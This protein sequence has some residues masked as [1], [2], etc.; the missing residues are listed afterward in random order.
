MD[1]FN[2]VVCFAVY[3]LSNLV[4][5][6]PWSVNESLGQTLMLTI[7]SILWG[8]V[9][10]SCIVRY[11]K[12]HTI[13]G[14]ILN[15]MIFIIEAIVSG[16][17]FFGIIRNAIDNLKEPTTLYGWGFVMLFPFVIYFFLRKLIERHKTQL[18]T[19]DFRRAC[20]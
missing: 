9:S 19:L 7:N 8:F 20:S 11:P 1:F 16:L 14:V 5:W 12:T 13:N 18:V 6:Y 17:I 4:L 15:S 10:Y 3:W 2:L